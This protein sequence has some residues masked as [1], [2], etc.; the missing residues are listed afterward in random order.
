MKFI[1]SVFPVAAGEGPVLI[2]NDS[3][4]R[5]VNNAIAE[6]FTR[7]GHAVKVA[8][9]TQEAL[10]LCEQRDPS[11]IAL[12]EIGDDGGTVRFLQHLQDR[13]SRAATRVCVITGT[14]QRLDSEP[15]GEPVVAIS[16][17]FS[18]SELMDITRE[19]CAV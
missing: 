16:P 4:D 11:L 14:W 2:V 5:S 8:S 3:L 1:D 7:N 9:D 17:S 15:R 19:L 6:R 10:E 12:G 13:L 18:L